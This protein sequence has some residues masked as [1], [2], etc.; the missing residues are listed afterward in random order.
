[1]T[2]GRISAY[3]RPSHRLSRRLIGTGCATV[4]I[5]PSRRPRRSFHLARTVALRVGRPARGAGLVHDRLQ[6]AGLV[7]QDLPDVLVPDH[8]SDERV[9]VDVVEVPALGAEA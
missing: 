7:A 8:D 4:A 9:G 3:G 6:L 2:V 5:A 1:A